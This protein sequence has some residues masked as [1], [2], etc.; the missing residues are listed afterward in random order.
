[1]V[2]DEWNVT[3]FTDSGFWPWT[4]GESDEQHYSKTYPR[5]ILLGMCVV[6]WST[7]LCPLTHYWSMGAS[8]QHLRTNLSSATDSENTSGNPRSSNHNFDCHFF[9]KSCE[10]FWNVG[11]SFATCNECKSSLSSLHT[12][13]G[14]GLRTWKKYFILT[15]DGSR[16]PLHNQTLS[17]LI[18]PR[19]VVTVSTPDLLCSTLQTSLFF[20]SYFF[21]CW[22]ILLFSFF[23]FFFLNP[24]LLLRGMG[25]FLIS[26]T[27]NVK[28]ISPIFFFISCSCFL[29]FSFS[30]N[31]LNDDNTY[32]LSTKS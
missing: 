24:P 15:F 8:K 31:H 11:R 23:F 5:I 22:I 13:L 10:A 27:I 6:F 1:M 26:S 29:T 7:Y 25:F 14:N 2:G 16:K 18:H 3:Q 17:P 20:F 19:R 9:K 12:S 28:F 21:F 32:C 30:W 4:I